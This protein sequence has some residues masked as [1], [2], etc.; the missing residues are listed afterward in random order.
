MM[1]LVKNIIF[2]PSN[3]TF[4][5]IFPFFLVSLK[6]KT[7]GRKCSKKKKKKIKIKI[8]FYIDTDDADDGGGVV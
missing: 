3:G 6:K 4:L 1:S 2:P 7:L 5:S 8:K